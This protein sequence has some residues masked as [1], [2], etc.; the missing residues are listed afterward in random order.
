[1][2]T[3]FL[4]LSLLFGCS[5]E[6]TAPVAD[7]APAVLIPAS[8][9]SEPKYQKMFGALPDAAAPTDPVGKAKVDLGRAL[10]YENRLSK[11]QDLSC[12]SCHRLDAYGVDNMPRSAGHKGQLGGRNSPTVLNAY[13]H[14]AQFWDGR[15]KDV[16]EQAKGPVNNPVEMA[17]VDA[18]AVDAILKSIPG[19]EPMF[20]AA[21]P[22]D[23]DPVNF[24]NAAKAIGAFERTLATP[25]P[26][27]AYMKG[28][29]NAL[30][31][32]QVAGMDTFV[33]TGCVTCHLGPTVGGTMYQ[34]I[35]LVVP[36]ETSDLGRMDVTK[37]ETDK[38]MFKVPS[39]RNIEKTAP[40]F[41]DGSVPTLDEAIV[42]MGK[43]QLGKDL[44]PEQIAS[45][46][47]F[48]GSLTGTVPADV[49]KPELPPSGP[50]TP[51]PDPS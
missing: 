8:P 46:R 49:G 44:T 32:E 2:S 30:T 14:F 5:V 28:D 20:K 13:L 31:A 16:E 19:Y 50:N 43:H 34:R 7:P 42:K 38:H 36:Y 39:L 24:D 45:I 51:K 29:T 6:P 22:E 18:P 27:D 48:L 33:Q 4:S 23:A 12:N 40:Y 35:G 10:Y 21:F 17:M 47:A 9:K 3:L 25:A 11:G 37:S 15:A 26:F 41:H 1:M